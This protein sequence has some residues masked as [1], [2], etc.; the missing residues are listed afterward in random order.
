MNR[1]G[2]GGS[3]ARGSVGPAA[4]SCWLVA[5]LAALF[6]CVSSIGHHDATQG[7]AVHVTAPAPARAN[8][9]SH[10]SGTAMPDDCPAGETCCALAAHHV[11]AV[12]YTPSQPEPVV[13]PEMPCAPGA[14]GPLVA[15]TPQTGRVTPSLHVLQVLRT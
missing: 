10:G 2:R 12:A 9:M 1:V 7:S 15:A 13:L 11:A 14:T 6:V 4:I 5:A 3:R 8:A